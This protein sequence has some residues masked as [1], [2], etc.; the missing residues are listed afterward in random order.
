VRHPPSTDGMPSRLAVLTDREFQVFLAISRGLSNA[1]VGY[2]LFMSEATVKSHV[3]R[4]LSK[5]D[6][7]DRVQ[8]VMLA[9]ECGVAGRTG[10]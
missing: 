6:L 2:E 4:I 7:R 10:A 9:Y 3:T 1:E 5:L 8:A